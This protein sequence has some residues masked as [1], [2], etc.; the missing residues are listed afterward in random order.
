[1]LLPTPILTNRRKQYHMIPSHDALRKKNGRPF[2]MKRDTIAGKPRRTW[3]IGKVVPLSESEIGHDVPVIA[4]PLHLP[5]R[6]HLVIACGEAIIS[7]IVAM[8]L[9]AVTEKAICHHDICIRGC[10]R[11]KY[12]KH[13]Q[14]T[15]L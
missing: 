7:C 2:H 11:N 14:Q 3:Q 4:I 10:V 8:A 5:F 15:R 6:T 9:S 12:E 1:M 13:N